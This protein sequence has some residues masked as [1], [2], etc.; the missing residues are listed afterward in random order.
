VGELVEIFNRHFKRWYN[1]P[2]AIKDEQALTVAVQSARQEIE[3]MI[4]QIKN[5]P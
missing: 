5:R 2:Y 1:V 4:I 3:H